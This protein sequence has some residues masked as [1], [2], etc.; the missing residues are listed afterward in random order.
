MAV[1]YA[2]KF[3]LSKVRDAGHAMVLGFIT[4]IISGMEHI[5]NLATTATMV[6]TSDPNGT[7]LLWYALASM[8]FTDR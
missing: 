6:G 8:N 1:I 2:M 5:N 3:S 7:F 4:G